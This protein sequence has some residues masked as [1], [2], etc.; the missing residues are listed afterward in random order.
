MPLTVKWRMPPPSTFIVFPVWV[1][2]N[3][4]FHFSVVGSL[5]DMPFR[6]FSTSDV[7]RLMS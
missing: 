2:S 6:L 5:F 3:R 1:T 7:G 4:S